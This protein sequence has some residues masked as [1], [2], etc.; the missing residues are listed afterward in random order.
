MPHFFR[1]LFLIL[2]ACSTTYGNPDIKII[3]STAEQLVFDWDMQDF[4]LSDVNIGQEILHKLSFFRATNGFEP[5]QPDIPQRSIT[6]GIPGEVASRIKIIS[7]E[8][9]KLEQINLAP[10]F[11]PHKE[12]NG[13]GNYQILRDEHFYQNNIFFPEQIVDQIPVAK[14]RDIYTENI[15]LR[16]FQYNPVEKT[17]IIYSKIRIQVDYIN[18][19]NSKS[20]FQSRSKIDYLYAQKM[21]NFEQAQFWQ[22]PKSSR[23]TK[24]AA[25]PVGTWY[26]FPVTEDGLYKITPTTLS[27]AGVDVSNLQIK[28]IQVF[29][30]AGH[31]L[32]YTTNATSYNPPF[33]SEV[34]L[35]EF[36]QNQNGLFE[37][38]DYLLLNAKALNSWFYEQTPNDFRYQQHLYATT[39]YYW[40][41]VSGTDGKRMMKQDLEDLGATSTT[42]IFTERLHIEEDLYNLLASGPDWYGNRFFGLS[43]SYTLNFDIKPD[44]SFGTSA[45][46]LV[47]LK[48]GSGVDYGDNAYYR[49]DF[50]VALNNNFIATNQTFTRYNPLQINEEGITNLTEGLNTLNFYYSGNQEG[51][52]AHLDWFE[53]YY[54]R[55]FSAEENQ[56]T[57]F[58]DANSFPVKYTISDLEALQDIFVFDLTN[59]LNPIILGENLSSSNG[60]ISFDL[61]A[62][63]HPQQIRVSSLSSTKI[64]DVESLEAVQRG[65]DLVSSTNQADFLIV[66]HKT[67]L[68]YAEEIA[69]RRAHL[70]SKV[71]SMDEIYFEFNAGVPDPTALRNF[72]RH[73]YKNWQSPAPSY[74]LLF[75]DGHYDYRNILLSDTMRVPPFEIYNISEINSRITDNYFVD[76][77]MVDAGFTYIDPDLAIGRLPIESTID[78]ER[79]LQK[80]ERYEDDPS[81]DGWQTKITFIADDAE[82]PGSSKEWEHQFQTETIATME[83]LRRFIKTKIYLSTYP[84]EPGGFGRIKPKAGEALVD[85]INQGTLIINYVG[86]GSPTQWAHEGVFVMSRDLNRIHNPGKLPFLVAATCDFG[87]FDDPHE[88]SFNEALIWMEESGTIGGLAA[89]RLVYSGPNAAFNESFYSHLFPIGQS[90][91]TIGAAKLLATGSS[92]NDQKYV[93][94]AD[95]TM[96]LADPRGGIQITSDLSDSLRALSEVEVTAQILNEGVLYNGFDGEAVLIVNDASYDSV[97]T[98]EVYKPIELP[99][100]TL[101]KGRITVHDGTLQGKFIVP[102][103]IRYTNERSGRIT[104]YAWDDENG[105]TAMG[106][107]DDLLFKGSI[108]DSTDDQGPNIDIYFEDQE[109]FSSGDLIQADPVL[110][111]ALTDSKG[112]NI[113][114][115]A[116]HTITIQIDQDV[117]KDISGFFTYEKD[118]YTNGQINYPLNALKSGNHELTLKAFDNLNNGNSEDIEF[119]ISSGS[120]MLLKEVVN[121]PNPFQENTRFTFQTN[122]SGAEVK[123]KIYTVSGRLIEELEGLSVAGFNNEISWDGRDQDGDLV[124]NGVYLYQIKLKDDDDSVSNIEKM[125]ITR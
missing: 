71:V 87:K 121:Y 26:K 99:G 96:H 42:N 98:G 34:P 21:I 80:I 111:A 123:I 84:S 101:F 19:N 118:S 72:I 17:L 102:K 104:L 24:S 58:A 55:N 6:I 62:S 15:S 78:A 22:T 33:T 25:M 3:S 65:Q 103:T 107:N 10:V 68:P 56:L 69:K 20:T 82:K 39:N 23:L 16:P 85:A 57:F 47:Q 60:S 9:R 117:P 63:A 79:Y 125:V 66:T 52:I 45:K 38:G 50:D 43:D 100:A 124:A 51:C 40:I 116:G 37:S 95:P 77:E 27:F 44:F 5:G 114:G 74:V 29:N 32:S 110:I 4:T 86:H 122:R 11:I 1:T 30:N 106:F 105:A 109:M 93:L 75:G 97:I 81:R 76:L 83:H 90:S 73:A 2:I 112:I 67:F 94:F 88:T 31:M 14:F 46:A 41:T 48:G 28:N 61:P 13:L 115:A 91:N 113:T 8:S 64:R 35:L 53:L 49:Y 36:D 120:G 92:T 108:V 7:S 54:P 18:K 59:P 70:T 12:S 119:N 89:A